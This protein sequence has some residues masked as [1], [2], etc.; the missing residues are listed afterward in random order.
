MRKLAVFWIAALLAIRASAGGSAGGFTGAGM[1]TEVTQMMNNV[2]L[3][4]QVGEAV[5]QTTAQIQ[6][7]TQ[8]IERINQLRKDAQELANPLGLQELMSVYQQ[9]NGSIKSAKA[10]AYGVT[11]IGANFKRLHPDFN[12]AKI[13]DLGTYASRVGRTMN[14]IQSAMEQG[15][16]VF[17]NSEN[18]QARMEEIG[19]L[20]NNPKGQTA[21]LQTANTINYEVLQQLR[22]TKV[23][24]QQVNDAQLSYLAAQTQKDSREINVDNEIRRIMMERRKRLEQ[25]PDLLYNKYRTN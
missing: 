23:Y 14:A 3:V 22:E 19:R 2:E 11:N 9:V 24:A 4:A 6:M 10:L 13:G 16:F 18:E 15:G 7:V 1:A 20:V 17:Q 21:A 8:G 5:S 12:N 25:R